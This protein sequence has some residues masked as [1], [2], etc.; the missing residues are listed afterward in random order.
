LDYFAWLE[1]F[2][3]KKAKEMKIKST[4]LLSILPSPLGLM[5]CLAC[6]FPFQALFGH[7][8]D[9]GDFLLADLLKGQW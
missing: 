4:Y 8:L 7:H 3:L 2:F 6:P 5:L 9:L 1:E